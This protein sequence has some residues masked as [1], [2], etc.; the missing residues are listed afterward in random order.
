MLSYNKIKGTVH[1]KDVSRESEVGAC[2]GSFSWYKTCF[3]RVMKKR[4][5]DFHFYP[6]SGRKMN[7]LE[8]AEKKSR[9][10]ST[11]KAFLRRG[12][13][14]F[15]LALVMVLMGSPA[16]AQRGKA[17]TRAGE[18]S[19]PREEKRTQPARS[20]PRVVD[21]NQ[22][23]EKVA[24]DRDKEPQTRAEQKAGTE[25]GTRTK[26]E[27]RKTLPIIEGERRG[28]PE[29]IVPERVIREK[30]QDEPG[31]QNLRREDAKERVRGTLERFRQDMVKGDSR[32]LSGLL[33]DRS[34][35]KI[36]IDSKGVNDTFNRGQAQYI[37]RE[38]LSTSD[39]RDLSFSRFRVS[40]SDDL[41]AYGVG[42][43][44]MRDRKS[45]K[46]MDRTVFVSMAREGE[47][48]VIREIRITE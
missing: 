39:H 25:S 33:S 9:S 4:S 31:S 3:S 26:R 34:R 47:A 23:R 46:I 43:L 36:T 19:R 41:N 27:T 17:A 30:Y 8:R 14:V 22:E 12:L 21:R 13:W 10:G 35:V 32:A 5:N 48:W 15:L 42:K 45:G 44:R 29:K 1:L 2:S 6:T 38:Y 16:R 11:G 7:V 37:L 28:R 40:S 18:T 24:R 20:Q